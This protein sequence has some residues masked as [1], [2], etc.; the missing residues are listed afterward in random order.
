MEAGD[1]GYKRRRKRKKRI[2]ADG[3]VEQIEVEA[4]SAEIWR[5]RKKLLKPSHKIRFQKNLCKIRNM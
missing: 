4:G 3:T 5:Q 1:I 2:K